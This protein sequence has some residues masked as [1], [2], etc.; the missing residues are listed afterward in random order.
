M[1]V[2][3]SRTVASP[4]KASLPIVTVPVS[5]NPARAR[6]PARLLSFLMIVPSPI[7][8]RSG[9]AGTTLEKMTTFRPIFAPSSLR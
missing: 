4:M 9:Q 1:L 3:M 2:P 7:D 5:M 6:Y 8:R